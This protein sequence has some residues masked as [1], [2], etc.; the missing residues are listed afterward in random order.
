MITGTLSG[1]VYDEAN[2]TGAI[3]HGDA[4]M[5]DLDDNGAVDIR[6][7]LVMLRCAL[8]EAFPY[9]YTY[10]GKKQVTLADVH[11]IFNQIAG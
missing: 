1:V 3:I 7:A 2:N 11:W 9:G 10:F 5:G 8:D 4:L 6:D